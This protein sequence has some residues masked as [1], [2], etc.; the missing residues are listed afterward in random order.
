MHRTERPAQRATTKTVF[1]FQAFA[2]FNVRLIAMKQ[3]AKRVLTDNALIRVTRVNPV[4]KDNVCNVKKI[5]PVR[6]ATPIR[7]VT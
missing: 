6:H 1:A 3:P 7:Q 2:S 4:T 5:R